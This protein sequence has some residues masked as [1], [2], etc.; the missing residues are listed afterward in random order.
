MGATSERGAT[1]TMG[2]FDITDL[3]LQRGLQGAGM[4]Q[5]LLAN[6]LANANT[7]GFKRSDVDFQSTLAAA[8]GSDSPSA[9]DGLAFQPQTDT[10]S[11]MRADGNNVDVD[12]ENSNLT[13]NAVEYEAMLTVARS[14]MQMLKTA[15]GG[16][17]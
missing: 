12:E 15:I 10:Q 17:A 13:E 9:L 4:R 1:P 3:V 16:G 2:L 5:Q 11:T 14:R 8:L 6:T 7:A